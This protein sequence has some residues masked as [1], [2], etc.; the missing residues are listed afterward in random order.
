MISDLNGLGNVANVQWYMVSAVE[1]HER[2]HITEW[3]SSLNPEF[4]TMKTT[5][6][7]LTVSHTAGMTAG[8]AITQIKA[9]PAYTNAVTG[10]NTRATTTFNNIADPNA[11]TN[12]AEHGVVDP[13]V[14]SIRAHATTQGWAA[15]PP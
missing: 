8:D 5:I 3:R 13:M 7:A 9:M 15:C 1:A 10:A 6:E 14:T 12:A 4:T 11:Q 2:V